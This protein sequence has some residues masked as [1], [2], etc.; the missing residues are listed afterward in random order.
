[1]FRMKLL[2]IEDDLKLAAH[3]SENFKEHGFSTVLVHSKAELSDA[4]KSPLKLE[5]VIMD[6]L[7]GNFD[8]KEMLGPLRAKWPEVP[9]IV[10]SA[11][12]TPNERSDLINAGADDYIGKPFSTNEL[13]ARMRALLRRTT[14]PSGN[15]LQVGN[16]VLDSMKR[17]V[18]VGEK[19]STLPAREFAILRTLAL[20]P[21]R[22]W[23]K[24]DL[25]DYVWGQSPEVETN[26]VESTI[27]NVRKKLEELGAKISI[28]NMRNAGY[29]IDSER[30]SANE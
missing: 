30:R 12:S 4:L 23:S 8:T 10:V 26:V 1:M 9:I 11:I 29:W 20:D 3:L 28:R 19:A 14:S 15:Y 7:L 22:I 5:F 24:E 17:I 13:I 21:T 27:A 6:R 16:L 25:L 18:S 2:L